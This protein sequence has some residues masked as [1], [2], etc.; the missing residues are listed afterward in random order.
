MGLSFSDSILVLQ[1]LFN[2]S[3]C[4]SFQTKNLGY[5]GQQHNYSCIIPQYAGRNARINTLILSPKYDA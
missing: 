3:V 4:I 1:F 2:K 5:Q